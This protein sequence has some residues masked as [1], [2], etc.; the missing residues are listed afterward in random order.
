MALQQEKGKLSADLS[1]AL[2]RVNSLEVS[3]CAGLID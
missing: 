3:V 1:E 2:S